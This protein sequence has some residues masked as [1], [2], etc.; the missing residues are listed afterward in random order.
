MGPL[1]GAAQA[2]LLRNTGC[3]AACD[4]A[5][6]PHL[7]C[8]R[9]VC[10]LAHGAGTSSARL[11]ISA[12][13]SVHAASHLSIRQLYSNASSDSKFAGTEEDDFDEVA[14]LVSGFHSLNHGMLCEMNA[15]SPT[16]QAEC[17]VICRFLPMTSATGTTLPT[18]TL[19]WPRCALI[20][21]WVRNMH[22]SNRLCVATSVHDPGQ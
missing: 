11:P 20:L 4:S 15:P 12:A 7:R 9:T 13:R 1:A 19:T 18:M 14:P 3:A 2:V 21:K 6:Q 16:H 8:C 17:F 10:S 22:F 5:W